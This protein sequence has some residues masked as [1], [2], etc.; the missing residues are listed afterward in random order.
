MA[1][2]YR[3]V[4]VPGTFMFTNSISLTGVLEDLCGAQSD[5]FRTAAMRCGASHGRVGC[6]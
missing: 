5:R 1:N 6:V 4:M 2:S 3:V